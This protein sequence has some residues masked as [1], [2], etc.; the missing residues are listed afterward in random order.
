[1]LLSSDT[2]VLLASNRLHWQKL[3]GQSKIALGRKLGRGLCSHLGLQQ[4]G[5]QQVVD[6]LPM[7]CAN[8]QCLQHMH[9]SV[10]ATAL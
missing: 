3:D 8:L 6:T 9:V 10:T 2:A 1:M 5:L 4:D 7:L